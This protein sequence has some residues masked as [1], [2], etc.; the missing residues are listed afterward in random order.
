MT[1]LSQR[2]TETP[3]APY[4]NLLSGMTTEEK[5]VVVAFLIDTMREQKP[6]TTRQIPASFKKLRGIVNVSKEEI[7]ND[8]H[9]AHIMQ[10]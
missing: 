5:Q 6:R 3:M 2:I 7:T 10:R 1:P 8:E 4:M 9:L